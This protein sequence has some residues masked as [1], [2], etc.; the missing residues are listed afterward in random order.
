[1]K[2]LFRPAFLFI[3]LMTGLTISFACAE[4][5]TEIEPVSTDALVSGYNRFGIDLFLRESVSGEGDNIFV[6]PV[7][8]A[9]CLGMA[10]NG[11]DGSTASEMAG[12]LGAASM[13]LG[14]YNS[15]NGT[16]VARL[17]DAGAGITLSIANSLWLKE[18]FPFRKEFV[19]RNEKYFGAGVFKLETEKEINGW[20]KERTEGMIPSIIDSVDPADIAILVN[21]IYF[22]GEWTIEFDEDNTRDKPFYSP[23]G[24]KTVPMMKRTGELVCQGNEL[25]QAVRLPYGNAAAEEDPAGGGSS[26][27]VFLPTGENTL[28]GLMEKLTPDSWVTWISSLAGRDGTIELPRFRAEYFSRLNGTLSGMGMKEAFDRSADFTK[29]CECSPGDVYISDVFHKAVVEVNEKG[30]EAAAATAIKMKLTS[31]MPV[32]DPFHMVV[33]RPFLIA[34]VDDDTGLILFMGAI[35]DPE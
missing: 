6:S 16:L 30:T 11:A 10:Y 12:M 8:V 28:A 7:S 13:D 1:M 32:G 35:S 17:S 4:T 25:F 24:E 27:Y 22:K 23:D 34:I 18:G 3:L 5:G 20:V 29:L 15:A 19:K 2:R 21:A 26:M 14:G 9:L 33:D 31:A